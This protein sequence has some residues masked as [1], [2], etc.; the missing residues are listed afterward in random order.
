VISDSGTSSA[1]L[2]GNP[3]SLCDCTYRCIATASRAGD[4]L[5]LLLHLLHDYR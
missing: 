4:L 5:L 2:K 3:P 1:V